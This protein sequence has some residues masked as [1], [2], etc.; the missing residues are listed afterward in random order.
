MDEGTSP[1][2]PFKPGTLPF[3]SRL[4]LLQTYLAVTT[5]WKIS[6]GN[7]P[8]PIADFYVATDAQQFVPARAGSGALPSPGSAW[9]RIIPSAIQAPEE[10][11]PK[12]ARA[13]IDFAR[14]WGTRPPRYFSAAESEAGQKMASLEGIERLDGTLFVRVAGL[15]MDQ[16]G[17]VHEGEDAGSWHVEGDSS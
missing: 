8:L 12:I 16:L 13:L 6:R 14:R 4:L 17:W 5:A 10:H 3:S 1:S 15:T 9:T 7:H 11:T 2:S